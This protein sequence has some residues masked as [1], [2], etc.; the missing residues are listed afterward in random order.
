[1]KGKGWPKEWSDTEAK[2][3]EERNAKEKADHLW[4]QQRKKA[5]FKANFKSSEKPNAEDERYEERRTNEAADDVEK[6]EDGDGQ[7]ADELLE[8]ENRKRKQLKR[9]RKSFASA[10]TFRG[11]VAKEDDYG[12]QIGEIQEQ[13]NERDKKEA[14]RQDELLEIRRQ[15]LKLQE[16]KNLIQAKQLEAQLEALKQQHQHFEAK[17]RERAERVEED[18]EKF[19]ATLH[20]MQKK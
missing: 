18:R 6:E 15:E 19:L 20:A 14:A 16:Q 8:E 1:M 2:K 9:D 7:T 10:N 5:T 3:K 13:Q 4:T 12:D 11:S 17:H